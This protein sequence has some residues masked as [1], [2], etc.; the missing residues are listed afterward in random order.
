MADDPIGRRLRDAEQR[1]ELAHRQVRAPIRRHEQHPVLQCQAPRPAALY[2][3]RALAP[4]CGHQPVE[5]ARAQPGEGDYPGRLGPRDHTR[6][7]KIITSWP[8]ETERETSRGKAEVSS[9]T[10]ATNPAGGEGDLDS[11]AAGLGLELFPHRQDVFSEVG[12]ERRP[13]TNRSHLDA[14]PAAHAVPL[15]R[16]RRLNDQA[17][18]RAG[19]DVQGTAL[20]VDQPHIQRLFGF[21]PFAPMPRGEDFIK[22]IPDQDLRT[23]AGPVQE[24][25][26]HL[27]GLHPATV[28]SVNV[29]GHTLIRDSP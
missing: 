2:R 19:R 20:A 3:L 23:C 7:T 18:V 25:L 11:D 10:V 14:P 29:P 12:G 1:G 8:G 6:H 9:P 21:L 28:S 4:Q 13:I 5:A 26:I 15:V 17:P 27:L 22:P 24:T 16:A